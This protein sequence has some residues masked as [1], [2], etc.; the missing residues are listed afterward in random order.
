MIKK[1]LRLREAVFAVVGQIQKITEQTYIIYIVFHVKIKYLKSHMGLFLSEAL[2]IA[3][4]SGH[5]R[6]RLH[7]PEFAERSG[8]AW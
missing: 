1:P 2:D 5:N 7:N 8:V 4:F 6:I 3:G